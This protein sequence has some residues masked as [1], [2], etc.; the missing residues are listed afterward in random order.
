MRLLTDF[1]R[2]FYRLSLPFSFP[3]DNSLNLYGNKLNGPLPTEIGELRLI[4]SLD[5]SENAFTGTLPT[6]LKKLTS[7][8]TFALHQTSGEINGQIPAF[9]V[10]PNLRELNLESNNFQGS[11]PD[12]FLAGIS[13]KSADIVIALGSNQLTGAIPA[14]LDEFDSLLLGL[15]GNQIT[16]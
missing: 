1:Y 7:L 12:T 16:G 4:H 10:F 11:L 15:Q 8:S 3:L 2:L 9:D 13:D 6:E 5:L 14:S